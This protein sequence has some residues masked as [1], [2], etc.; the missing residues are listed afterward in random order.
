MAPNPLAELLGAFSKSYFIVVVW[1]LVL[2]NWLVHVP[3]RP[4]LH[5]PVA[6][7][8]GHVLLFLQ[9]A[10]YL[11]AIRTHPGAPTSSSSRRHALFQPRRHI[12]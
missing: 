12:I 7:V 2:L 11:S 3:C 4:S 10:A 1:T 5:S 8:F 9:V 6:L